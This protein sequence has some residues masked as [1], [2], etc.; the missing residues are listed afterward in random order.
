MQSVRFY[1]FDTQDE[2]KRFRNIL[3]DHGFHPKLFKDRTVRFKELDRNALEIVDE[4]AKAELCESFGPLASL[5]L[6]EPDAW[7]V[8][9]VTRV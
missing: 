7:K 4:L 3:R 8:R 5:M 1:R 9:E 2:A 6:Y